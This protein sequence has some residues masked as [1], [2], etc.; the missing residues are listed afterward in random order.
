MMGFYANKIYPWI[1]DNTEPKELAALRRLNLKDAKEEILEIG[2]GTGTN[3]PFYPDGVKRISA[4]EPSDAMRPRAQKR[5]SLSQIIVDWHQGKGES[6]P[7]HNNS[8]DTV[9][10]TGIL[11]SVNDVD[12][13]LNELFRVLKPGGKFHF[14]EHGISKDE[15]I[16]RL[17]IKFNDLNKVIACGCNLTRDI[18]NHIRNSH[19]EIIELFHIET[20]TG[21][22]KLYPPVRG[23]A[24]KKTI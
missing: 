9:V 18:E 12:G 7:F 11:C 4:V 8:F 20:F 2:I 5:A 22:D 6:L 10:S 15:K 24:R 17:Q 23:T 21:I 1:L 19:F 13:V 14:L 3:L 16:K